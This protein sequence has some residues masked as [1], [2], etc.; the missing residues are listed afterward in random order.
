MGAMRKTAHRVNRY[1]WLA[2]GL[3]VG[4]VLGARA[5]RQRYD[6]LTAWARRTSD[7]FG[8]TSAV[9]RVADTAKGTVLDLRDDAAGRTREALDTGAQT[10]A[11]KIE[12]V[13]ARAQSSMAA[14]PMEPQS[15]M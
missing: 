11:D 3:G 10:V 8:V 7:D 14:Q 15:S 9:G 6:Q 4:Y 1:T 12:D 13:G 2:V 5:G